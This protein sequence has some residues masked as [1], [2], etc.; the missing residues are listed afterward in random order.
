MVILI[1]RRV[2]IKKERYIMRELKKEE[3][4]KI[5]GG[6]SITGSMLNAIYKTIELIYSIG[7][8]LGSYIRRTVEKKM[9]DI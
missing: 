4:L 2:M 6:T 9:C 8:S 1:L 3:M 7:E 5:D